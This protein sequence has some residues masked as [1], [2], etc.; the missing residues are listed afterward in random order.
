MANELSDRFNGMFHDWD[1]FFNDFN[2]LMPAFSAESQQLKSDV[3]DLDDH[4]EVSVDVPGI[5]KK[6]INLSY[7]GDTLTV[8]AT[9]HSSNTEKDDKGNIITHE[10]TEGRVQRSYYLPEVALDKIKAQVDDGVLKITLSKSEN[11]DKQQ[12]T[13]D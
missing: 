6:D 4:Y 12:I 3:V 5:N 8:T 1:H 10:R 7:Q 13:I 11:S 2:H 9:R